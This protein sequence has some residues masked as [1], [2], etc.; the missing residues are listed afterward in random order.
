M[1][2]FP[3]KT[4]SI[5]FRAFLLYLVVSFLLLLVPARL[6]NPLRDSVLLPFALLQRGCIRLLSG[7][8]RARMMLTGLRTAR[9]D[10]LRLTREVE[11]L[12]A[13]L[14]RENERRKAAESK[15]SQIASLPAE[16]GTRTVTVAVASYDPSPLRRS[17]TLKAGQRSGISPNAAVLW[18]GT[19]LGRVE[20]VGP[21]TCRVV[22]LTDRRCSAA[23]RCTRS[24]VQGVLE[25]I[26]GGLCAVKYISPDADVQAGDVFVTSGAEEI[27]PP[28]VLV[29]TCTMASNTSGD[30][31]MRIEVRPAFETARL[32]DAV[33][34]L[35]NRPEPARTDADEME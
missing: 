10:V 1:R 23:V 13:Q 18:H 17:V 32:E 25:G 4:R 15:L 21:W 35:P 7:M 12:R 34:L 29:G 24:R 22:L 27:F 3:P 26:G 6:T 14:A 31:F 19:L 20:S 9:Q 30:V 33:I 5:L 8:R 16:T 28:G 2:L 11:E